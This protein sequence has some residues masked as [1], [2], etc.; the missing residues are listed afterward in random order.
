MTRQPDFRM[1]LDAASDFLLF[2]ESELEAAVKADFRTEERPR[3]HQHRRGK[4]A[5]LNLR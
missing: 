5:V 1:Y 3:G 2:T 4:P